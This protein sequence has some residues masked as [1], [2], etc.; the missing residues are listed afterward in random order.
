MEFPLNITNK[1]I[2]RIL[3]AQHQT[4]HKTDKIEDKEDIN[5][6]HNIKK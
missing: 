2:F 5:I 4:D 6:I 3:C 1:Y